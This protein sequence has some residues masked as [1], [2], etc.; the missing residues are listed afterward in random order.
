MTETDVRTALPDPATDVTALA[1]AVVDLGRLALAFGRIDRTA[2]YHPD[3]VTPES[4]SDHTVMLG[5]IACAL[6]AKCF[7]QLDLGKVAQMALVHDAPE[8]YA[9]DTPTLRITEAGRAAKVARERQAARRLHEEFFGRLTW[10]PQ[11]VHLYESQVIPEARFVRGLDKVLPKIVHLLDGC[12]GLVRQQMTRTELLGVFERQAEDMAGYV[13]EFG[14]LMELRAELVGRVLA[15]PEV[16]ADD[17]RPGVAE[18][19]AAGA[20]VSGRMHFPS[21]C[22]LYRNEAAVFGGSPT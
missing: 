10:F 18:A 12:A 22:H 14:E 1:D 13:G 20:P 17:A 5:W 8:V 3:G 19:I 9:G 7:P 15:R 11:A 6:A 16:V 4:D 21:E 2:V